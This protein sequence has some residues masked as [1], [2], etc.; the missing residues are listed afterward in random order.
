MDYAALPPEINSARMYAGAGAAPMTAAAAAW[1]ALGAELATTAASY[2]S[3][4]ST[5]ADEEWRGPAATAMAPA[6]RP[7]VAWLNT[8][9]AAAEH[10]AGQASASA[11][12]YET[13][14]AMT[15]P[16]PVVAA[17]RAQLA[18]LVA[19]NVLG[20]NTPA[21]AANEAHYGEMWAQDAAAMYGYAGSSATAGRLQPLSSPTPNTNPA[22]PAAQAAAVSGA[23]TQTELSQVVANMPTA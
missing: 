3:V 15:V 23:S 13:A 20:Q 14:F 6:A 10:A 17:N 11:A 22:G 1:N 8:T 7:Y 5:R 19:S 2:A 21:I 18:A 16:P 4:I 9:A 12:A